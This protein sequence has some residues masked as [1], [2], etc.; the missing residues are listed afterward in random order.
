M[1][2]I[3]AIIILV[4]SFIGLTSC[5]KHETV[6]I[7][8]K[9]QTISIN[10]KYYNEAYGIT[11]MIDSNEGM[12]YKKYS[13]SENTLSYTYQQYDNLIFVNDHSGNSSLWYLTSDSKQL[14][15]ISMSSSSNYY[16]T[17]IYVKQ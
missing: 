17:T 7:N 6:T 5:T 15:Q 10:A 16:Y 3:L 13:S 4:F 9:E 2:K 8:N 11:V 1:K 14:I 12:F